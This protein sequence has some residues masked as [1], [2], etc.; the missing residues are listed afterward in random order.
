M[1]K[2]RFRRK[3]NI[4]LVF[5]VCSCLAWLVSRLSENYTQG[6]SFDL[7]YVNV[8]DSLRLSGASKNSVD[9]RL[10]A[11]GFQFLGFNFKSKQI[12]IDL[13]NLDQKGIQYYI[14]QKIYRKQIQDQLTA[15]MTLLEA[16][17]D[18]IFFKFQRLHQKEVPVRAEVTVGLGQNYLL[19]DDLEIHP[20]TIMLNGP[21][22]EVSKVDFISTSQLELADLTSDFERRVA[23][24]RAEGLQNTTYSMDSVI[25]S[26]KVFRFSEKIVDI[27]IRVINLPEGTEIRTFPETVS[28]LCKGKLDRLKV[29]EA[30]DFD[31]V[32]DYNDVSQSRQI[33]Q[34]DLL[35]FPEVLHSAQLLETEVEFILK[36]E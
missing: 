29:L 8:P 12:A 26:G 4:F 15:S 32:G 7:V 9:V 2:G 36:R 30:S 20:E 17:S 5:L 11:S 19:E 23:L 35:V 34:L 14:P 25:V 3:V 31:I 33:L 21:I 22:D 18:T 27:P 10:R 24:S 13:E 16:D 28:V 1:E 6:T